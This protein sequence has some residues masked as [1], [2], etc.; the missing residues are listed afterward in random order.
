MTRMPAF[1]AAMAIGLAFATAATPTQ[2]QGTDARDLAQKQLDEGAR[3]FDEKDA[4]A[5]AETY[6]EDAVLSTLNYNK[7]SGTY[8]VEDVRGRSLIEQSYKKLFDGMN[9]P[10][11]SKNTVE[12][13]RLLGSRVLLIT[14]TFQPDTSNNLTVAF[15][16]T[17]VKVGE[18]WLKQKLMIYLVPEN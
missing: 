9:N 11:T 15:T 18:K 12:S 4:R 7:N 1:L 14:G 2:A 13:A 16:Q 5:M 3:Q 17:R 8:E 6:T 10:T